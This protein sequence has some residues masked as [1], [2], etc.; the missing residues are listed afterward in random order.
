[1]FDPA[2]ERQMTAEAEKERLDQLAK[3]EHFDRLYSST[4]ARA[5]VFHIPEH[6]LEVGDDE[7]A[8]K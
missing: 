5:H 6:R 8:G 1:M 3:R 7:L 2:I 4:S